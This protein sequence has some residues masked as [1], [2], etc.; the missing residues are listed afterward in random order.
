M[1][2]T[3]SEKAECGVIFGAGVWKNGKPS[4]ALYDRIKT[5]VD[6]YKNKNIECIIL[7]GADSLHGHEVDVMKK[8]LIEKKIPEISLKYDYK[9]VNTLATIKNLPKNI[10]SF[11]MI[12]NDFHL[13]RI[14]MIIWKENVENVS[15][16]KAKYHFGRYR[17]ESYFW[18]REMFGLGWYFLAL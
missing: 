8:V 3:F 15:Y 9:G 12:S 18:A 2:H 4:H 10:Q 6:L 11:V 16:Q 5:A 7:S 13:G 1:N 17:K 14:R